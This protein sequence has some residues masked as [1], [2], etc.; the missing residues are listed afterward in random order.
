[1]KLQFLSALYE[2]HGPVA[3]V[4]LDTSRDIDDPDRAID[5]RW[6]SLRE[7]LLAHGADPATVGAAGRA[8][9]TDAPVSGPHGQAV[10]AAEGE[11][12]LAACLPEPPVDSTARY[13]VVPDAL[14]LALQHAPDIPYTALVVHRT[15]TMDTGN[16]EDELEVERESGRWPMSRVAARRTPARRIP[17][18][19]WAKEAEQLLAEFADQVEARGTEV[20]VLAGDPWA[21]NTLT[22]EAPRHLHDRFVRLR[23]GHPRRPQPGRALLE[24]ELRSLLAGKVPEHDR[25][26]LDAFHAQRAR[27]PEEVEGLAATV[28][29]LQRGQARALL[30]NRP[31]RLPGRL[32]AGAEPTHL[33]LSGTELTAF[34]VGYYWEE[35]PGAALIRAAYG[36]HAELLVVEREELALEDGLGVL[37]RY[38]DTDA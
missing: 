7:G 17:V 31:A 30:V 27:R 9:G 16:A 8:V 20:I 11:L 22:R 26:R 1:M 10:F 37:L 4:Y 15:H 14:P 32:W 29:A 35:E 3:S 21:A 19:G 6:R 36:T 28:T 2:H 23:D 18:D 38:V 25:Q 33:A 12:L 34:G 13:G 5:L 24:A